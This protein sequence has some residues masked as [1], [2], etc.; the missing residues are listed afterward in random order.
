MDGADPKFIIF[1]F[2]MLSAAVLSAVYYPLWGVLHK[3]LPGR[4]DGLL[5]RKPFFNDAELINYQVFPLSLVKSLNYS[6]LI[7]IPRMAKR[8][9][10]KNLDKEIRVSPAIRV[11]C[12]IHIWS[13][14]LGVV[15]FFA[16]FGYGG[17]LYIFYT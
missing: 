8:K 17:F 7:A 5:F 6:Y 1:L 2:I 10:F 4:L 14:L 13:A 3:I 9:R 11:A 12:I 15:C 16:I